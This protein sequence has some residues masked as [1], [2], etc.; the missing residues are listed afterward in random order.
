MQPRKVGNKLHVGPK[1]RLPAKI[2]DVNKIQ[3]FLVCIKNAQN[4]T[5]NYFLY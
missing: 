5:K 2:K 4:T 1:Q 3:G